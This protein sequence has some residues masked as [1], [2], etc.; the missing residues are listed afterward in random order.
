MAEAGEV[1]KAGISK[2]VLDVSKDDGEDSKDGAEDGE[3][4][5]V[6]PKPL[7]TLVVFSTVCSISICSP[8]FTDV[9][10]VCEN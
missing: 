4:A 7:L 1:R 3:K 8:D 2:V 6:A 9:D 5:L 10:M